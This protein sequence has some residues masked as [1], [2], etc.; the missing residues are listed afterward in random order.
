MIG[1]LL[2]GVA[3]VAGLPWWR[4]VLLAAVLT[5]PLI[6]A[7]LIAIGAWR[8]RRREDDRS[9]LFCEGV[10]SELRAGATLRRALST[11]AL[12]VGCDP[13]RIDTPLGESAAELAAQFEDV[14]EELRLTIVTA[15]RSES[16][17]AAIF[18]ELGSLAVAQS[19]I[20]R[21]VRVATAPG[22]ATALLF[23]G[24]PVVF[25][26]TRLSSGEAQALLASPQQRVVAL[27]GLG[28]FLAGL[29]LATFVVW[30][31]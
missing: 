19:E 4:V 3:I 29:A 28:L 20:R 21:E 7:V 16:G 18:E 13:P 25:V 23:I 31:A 1:A 2:L 17:A 8:S 26:L 22:R 14:A 9:A 11:S 24:A 27:L 10:A 12:S 5:T 6:A 15:T 30:R